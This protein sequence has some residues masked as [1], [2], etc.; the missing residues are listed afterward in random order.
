[1]SIIH[2]YSRDL[3]SLF[4][5]VLLVILCVAVVALD[6]LGRALAISRAVVQ[7]M[8]T[9]ETRTSSPIT[10]TQDAAVLQA[11]DVLIV[12]LGKVGLLEEE[13]SFLAVDRG[14]LRDVRLLFT[15]QAT[16]HVLW[17]SLSTNG[18][19]GVV[20]AVYIDDK[21]VER[22]EIVVRRLEQESRE[23]S[24]D[25]ASGVRLVLELVPAKAAA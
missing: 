2:Y 10:T 7:R 1:M 21:I 22:Q 14:E 18:F 24:A 11:S 15:V 4:A 23:N 5:I 19:D 13:S 9:N 6:R 25:V 3:N 8:A 20:E 12:V 16:D 17:E